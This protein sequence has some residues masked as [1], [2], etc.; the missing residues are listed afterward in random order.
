MHLLKD[1]ILLNNGISIVNPEDIGT[2]ILKGIS[3][4]KLRVSEMTPE[5]TQFNDFSDELIQ[6]FSEDFF[7]EHQ[8]DWRIPK[9][10]LELDLIEYFSKF[11]TPKNETRILEELSIII[12][13]NLENHLRTL[14]YLVDYLEE[15]NI[16]W[17][18]GR[19]SSCA[20][21]LLYLIGLHCV[22]CIKFDISYK[23]FFK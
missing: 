16:V 9:K 11:I 22:D 10:Y 21:Y 17:G 20:C 14:I 1:R 12:E 19:G 6:Q 23:E 13:R 7:I 3:I 8:F 2:F 15:N 5:I 18:L 4:D